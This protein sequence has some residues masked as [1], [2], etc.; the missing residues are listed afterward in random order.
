[1]QLSR[2]MGTLCSM[3]PKGCFV[4]LLISYRI[5]D[6]AEEI[7]WMFWRSHRVFDGSEGVLFCFSGF[8]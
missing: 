6:D 8:T 4:A 7:A 2:V 3:M 5:S 1:M